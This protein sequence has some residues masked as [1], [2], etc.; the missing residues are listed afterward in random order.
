LI[1][2]HLKNSSGSRHAHNIDFHFATG[3]GGGA[4]NTFVVP[5]EEA[6]IEVRATAPGLYMYH[7]AAPDIPTHIANGMY[8]FVLV[9]PKEGLPVVDHEYSSTKAWKSWGKP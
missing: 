1:E 3:P 6:V 9:E 7:C 5:G 2:F 8:G 4:K